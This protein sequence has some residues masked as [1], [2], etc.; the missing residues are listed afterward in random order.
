[1]RPVHEDSSTES[2][3]KFSIH[4]QQLDFRQGANERVEGVYTEVHDR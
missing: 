4:S 2:T 3:N 1:M